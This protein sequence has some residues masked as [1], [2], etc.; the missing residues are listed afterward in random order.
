MEGIGSVPDH[1]PVG[2]GSMSLPDQG[3]SFYPLAKGGP[4]VRS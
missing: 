4:G 1:C 2:S 3:A